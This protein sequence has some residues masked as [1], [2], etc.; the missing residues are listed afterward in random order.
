MIIKI[1]PLIN[2]NLKINKYNIQLDQNSSFFEIFLAK[3]NGKP[4]TDLPCKFFLIFY[5]IIHFYKCI[6]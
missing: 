4:K 2:E 6:P 1:I 5:L 3:K